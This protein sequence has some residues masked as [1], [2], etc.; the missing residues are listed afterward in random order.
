MKLEEFKRRVR[1]EFGDSLEHVTPANVPEFVQK[2]EVELSGRRPGSRIEIDE[3]CN[4]YEEVIRDFFVRVLDL[5]AEDAVIRL[6]LL[7]IDLTFTG[8]ESHYA[9]QLSRIFPE[10]D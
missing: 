8:I 4:T 9:D 5:P 3:P 10:T 2:M 7:S 6:W 1:A